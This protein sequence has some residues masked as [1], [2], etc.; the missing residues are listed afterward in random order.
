MARCCGCRFNSRTCISVLKV[1]GILFA[2]VLLFR[3]LKQSV[4]TRSTSINSHDDRVTVTQMNKLAQY[5]GRKLDHGYIVTTEY[6][7]QQAAG[8]RGLISQQCWVASFRLPMHIVEP[9]V[10]NSILSHGPTFWRTTD[11]DQGHQKGNLI[12]FSDYYDLK[13][14]NVKSLEDQNPILVSWEDFIQRAPRKVIV[15]TIQNIHNK[16]FLYKNSTSTCASKITNQTAEKRFTSDC[17]T[18]TG[19]TSS[20]YLENMNFSIVRTVCFNCKYGMLSGF[21]PRN[22]TAHIFGKLKPSEVTVLFNQWKYSM[23]LT[24]KCKPSSVCKDTAIALSERLNTSESLLHDAEN[25][26]RTVARK[27]NTVTIM[28][29]L[30]WYIIMYHREML[31]MVTKVTKCLEEVEDV[32]IKVARGSIPLWALD[33]GKYGSGTYNFTL[34]KHN[35]SETDFGTL[36]NHVKSLVSKLHTFWTFKE[37]ENSFSYM[38]GQKSEDKGYVAALQNAVA[39]RSDCLILMGG[40]HF[41]VLALKQY[42]DNHPHPSQVCIHLVCMPRNWDNMFQSMISVQ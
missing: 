12:K 16:C 28:I 7:G 42:L 8:V 32:Y 1:A 2:V 5:N 27:K 14:F 6:T 30:E 29:R 22:F 25:Y 37:W 33:I 26:I 9:Y 31:Q 38:A 41:Q 39:G 35:M 21:L 10:S 4:I 3:L 13:H 40:G 19:D 15:V 18:L 17:E 24:P 20:K 34:S 23:A 11:Q 36:V